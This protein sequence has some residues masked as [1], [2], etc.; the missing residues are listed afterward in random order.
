MDKYINL[1]INSGFKRVFADES[2]QDLLISLL[3]S[4][5]PD[6]HQIAQLEFDKTK[7]Q[8]VSSYDRQ[9]VIDLLCKTHDGTPFLVELQKAE[10]NWFKDRSTY[11]AS[12]PIQ[13]RKQKGDWNSCLQAIYAIGILNFVFDAADRNAVMHSAR[14][15]H[16][17]NQALYDKL[18]F[19]YVTLPSF[20]ASLPKLKT[21]REKWL[22]LFRHLPELDSIPEVFHEPV[23]LK[24]FSIAELN[25]F[26][27]IDRDDYQLSLN[28]YRD[29][30]N[31]VDTAFSDGYK[32]GLMLA[33]KEREEQA[34]LQYQQSVAKRLKTMAISA[35]QIAQVTGLTLSEIDML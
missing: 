35:E 18:T 31:I 11:F 27:Q 3:N 5:L 22:Y 15:S 23:F 19:I 34:A 33:E 30:K 12:F 4:L 16:Q 21:L 2:N 25:S 1:L 14:M 13:K 29:M 8:G 26:N 10:Q 32:Q 20:T 17:K 6:Q 24:L 9:E 28:Y 7:W